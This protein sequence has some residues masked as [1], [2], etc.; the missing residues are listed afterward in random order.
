VVPPGG[1]AEKHRHAGAQ[2]YAFIQVKGSSAQDRT[3]ASWNTGRR[4]LLNHAVR[5]MRSVCSGIPN[6][7]PAPSR[8]MKTYRWALLLRYLRDPT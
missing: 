7:V 5:S 4:Q 1:G 2:L 8:R 3:F 6:K